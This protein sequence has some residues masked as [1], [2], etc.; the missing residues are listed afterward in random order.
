MA[1]T[2]FT[3]NRDGIFSTC[4]RTEGRTRKYRYYLPIRT[5]ISNETDGDGGQIGY[6]KNGK[7]RKTE[8]IKI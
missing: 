8:W 7:G 2:Y 1:F 6:R 5:L 3:F 4:N